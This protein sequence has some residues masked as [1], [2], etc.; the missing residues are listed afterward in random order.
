M[1]CRAHGQCSS[2]INTH[3]ELLFLVFVWHFEIPLMGFKH[4]VQMKQGGI[5][6]PLSPTEHTPIVIQ[7]CLI[8][9]IG[10]SGK[11]YCALFAFDI[12]H[13]FSSDVGFTNVLTM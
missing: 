4:Q 11:Y 13:Y 6:D 9:R 7:L 1:Y 3:R 5:L 2:A 12:M 10:L 8:S